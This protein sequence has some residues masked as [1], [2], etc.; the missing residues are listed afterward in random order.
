MIAAAT[1]GQ[2]PRTLL[3]SAGVLVDTTNSNSPPRILLAERNKGHLQGTW[4]FPGGKVEISES[5]EEALVRELREELGVHIDPTSLVPVAFS[6]HSYPNF[7]PLGFSLSPT[8]DA[9]QSTSNRRLTTSRVP[10]DPQ[11]RPDQP[12]AGVTGRYTKIL[13][14]VGNWEI[15][16]GV[17]TVTLGS[18]RSG[19]TL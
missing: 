3:V 1:A 8:S 9:D 17:Y 14:P 7:H 5:P 2:K 16:R 6:S 10:S 15:I 19:L 13:F 11:I 12:Q 18:S 4:E